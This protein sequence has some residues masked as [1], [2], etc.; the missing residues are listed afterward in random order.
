MTYILL[1]EYFRFCPVYRGYFQHWIYLSD[2]GISYSSH[3]IYHFKDSTAIQAACS[4]IK[5]IRVHSPQLW[6][7]KDQRRFLTLNWFG[8][9]NS[10]E[11]SANAKL[12]SFI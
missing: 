10:Q 9:H 4:P 11:N 8:L 2:L 3:K 6:I 5:A 7:L 1:M 12:V